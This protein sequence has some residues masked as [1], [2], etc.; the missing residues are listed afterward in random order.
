MICLLRSYFLHLLCIW[1]GEVFIWPHFLLHTSEFRP[2]L[3]RAL[4]HLQVRTI[5][6]KSENQLLQGSI[7]Q[8]SDPDTQNFLKIAWRMCMWYFMG[9]GTFDS[10]SPSLKVTHISKKL[11]A[12]VPWDVISVGH[13]DALIFLK[14]QPIGFPWRYVWSWLRTRAG[15]SGENLW[16]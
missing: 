12:C 9:W 8:W 5:F 15:T 4:K 6:Q 11:Q 14:A 16:L 3:K 1:C 10:H 7:S 13:T 2:F